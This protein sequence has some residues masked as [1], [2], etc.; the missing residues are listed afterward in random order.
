MIVTWLPD[1]VAL[2]WVDVEGYEPQVL[3][4]LAGLIARSVPL[5]FEFTPS[6][7]SPDVKQ[8]LAALL[9]RHY[10]T[11]HSL[12]RRDAAAPVGTLASRTHTDDVLVY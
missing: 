11:V 1:S 2:I 6:R 10:T 8:R 12:G 5:A 4:G 3:A 7:Y 9:A